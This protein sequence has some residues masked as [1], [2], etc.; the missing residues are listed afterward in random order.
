[1]ID[2]TDE[3]IALMKARAMGALPDMG[4]A[5]R[6]AELIKAKAMPAAMFDTN[7]VDV[8]DVGC[9]T[10]HF[11]RTFMRHELRFARYT[12]L[13]IDPAMWRAA[14]DT[15]AA[16]IRDGTAEF[17]NE[18]LEHFVSRKQ[19]DFVIC[20]NAFM[21]FASAKTALSNLLRAT[22]H[23]LIIRS[24]FTDSNYRIV[25]AQTRQNHDKSAYDELD[26]FDDEGNIRC[27]DFWNMYSCTYMEALVSSVD[28]AAKL[29]WIEDRNVVSS[30]E[31]ESKLNIAKRGATQ[32]LE[33]HEISYPFI[34]PWKWL[35]ITVSQ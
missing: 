22:R 20:V 27:Y 9:A 30:L 21:Y 8:L 17:I 24:Y 1:M 12:G 11:L 28:P 7:A 3:Y 29:E 5:L 19:F 32:L 34:L 16:E 14:Q 26:V 13:E 18:D 10:G 35:A 25:R 23:H 33:G 2:N 15:W 31:A 6:V 4:C